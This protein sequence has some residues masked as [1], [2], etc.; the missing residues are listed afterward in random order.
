MENTKYESLKALIAN[1]VEMRK[2]IENL[3]LSANIEFAERLSVS[4]P[5]KE[6]ELKTNEW[7]AISTAKDA[8]DSMLNALGDFQWNRDWDIIY[9]DIPDFE[10]KRYTRLGFDESSINSY[11]LTRPHS[12]N[13]QA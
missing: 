6:K 2:E 4:V 3:R 1:A 9:K 7:K 10:T 8:C 5:E 11:R 12:D 13:E